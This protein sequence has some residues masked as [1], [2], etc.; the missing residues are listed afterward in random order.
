MASGGCKQQDPQA[1]SS[2]PASIFLNIVSA[3][4]RDF[5]F[6]TIRNSWHVR[7]GGGDGEEEV[8]VVP[9][10]GW[11]RMESGREG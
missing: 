9:W 3:C 8:V 2:L 1:W 6:P 4:A 7:E 5:A 11:L 10:V